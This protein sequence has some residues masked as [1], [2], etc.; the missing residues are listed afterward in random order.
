MMPKDRILIALDV[1]SS[2]KAF[3]IID[4][5][6][7][8]V[9][10]F[11]INSLF[12]EEGPQIVK[13]IVE[14]GGKVFLDLKYH[15]IPNTVANY[16]KA[17][18]KLGVYMFNIHSTGGFEMMKACVESAEKAALEFNTKKPIILAVT[19]LTSIDQEAL[20]KEL[21]VNISVEE[22]VVHLAKLAKQAGCDGVVASA[23]ETKLIKEACGDD[24]IVVTPGIR[25]L[26]AASGDQKRIV[27]P[28]QA[29][30]DGSDYLV[31]GRAITGQEDKV[32]A[33]K[34][35]VEELSLS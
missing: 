6:R 30:E 22:Q 20:N 29:L 8:Y 15:D 18:T 3:A 26:W 28:K 34:K 32:E 33:A 9:G 14:K 5:V 11:K 21:N 16:A 19:V 17:A 2:E 24:F 10:G 35:I 4:E 31:I 12:N 7:D 1:D 23:K 13:E 27:T 25:P